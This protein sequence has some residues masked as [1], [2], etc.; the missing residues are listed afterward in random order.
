MQMVQGGKY[1]FGKRPKIFSRPTLKVSVNEPL[2]IKAETKCRKS[3]R[4]TGWSEQA[5]AGKAGWGDQGQRKQGQEEKEG[6]DC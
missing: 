5:R 2:L 3:M 4:L 1:C 6:R